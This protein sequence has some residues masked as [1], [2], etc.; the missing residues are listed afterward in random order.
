M[1]VQTETVLRQAISERIKPV[2]FMNKMDL[3]LLTLQCDMEELYQIFQRAIENVNVI[4]ATYEGED[5]PMGSIAVI[6][7]FILF[8]NITLCQ[9]YSC[10]VYLTVFSGLT[11]YLKSFFYINVACYPLVMFL[12]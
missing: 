8:V 7:L 3:A 4:I 12:W 2:L 5:S 1:S 9:S 11:F 6:V 10:I